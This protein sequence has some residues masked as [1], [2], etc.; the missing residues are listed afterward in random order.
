MLSLVNETLVSALKSSP[1]SEKTEALSL[2]ELGGKGGASACVDGANSL[3]VEPK[4]SATGAA[5]E[6]LVGL[7]LKFVADR[8]R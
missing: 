4:S 8:R 7:I 1:K 5:I 3:K 2:C 6:L